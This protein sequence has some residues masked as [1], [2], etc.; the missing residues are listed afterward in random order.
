[1]DV[2]QFHS[3][4]G[5]FKGTVAYMSPEQARGELATPASD[6]YAY[7][8]LLQELCSGRAPY[9]EAPDG[10]ALLARAQRGESEPPTGMPA[11]LRVLVTRLKAFAPT[12]R[13]TA[14]DTLERLRWIADAPRRLRRNLAVAALILV[15]VGGASRYAIDLSRERNAAVAARD[16]A[17]KRRGQAEGLIGFMVGDLRSKLA[18]VGR[19]EILDE[20][21]KQALAY[22]ASVPSD[23]LTNEELYRRSQ[24]LHQLGQVRQ[25]R[26]DF[27]GAL[28]AAR[29]SRDWNLLDPWVRALLYLGRLDEASRGHERLMSIGYRE[30]GYMRLW[31]Q[32]SGGTRALG[33][34]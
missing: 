25:A 3:E 4:V 22:F 10:Y 19:L 14:L 31:E 17:D 27:T 33:R 21:G 28:K 8:L 18:A 24:A 30:P 23:A 9:G 32:K 12:Q 6:M 26:A 15:A 7:G 1:V 11:H 16:E 13:P 2:S 29:D 20:V 5:S 34:P